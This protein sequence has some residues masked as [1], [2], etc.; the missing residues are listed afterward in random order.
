[1]DKKEI[2]EKIIQKKEFFEL[3]KKEIEK[4]FSKFEKRQTSE[5]EKIR[6]TRDLLRKIYFSFGSRKLLNPRIL[7]KKS[8]EQVLNKHFSTRERLP[9]YEEVYGKIFKT[10][11]T[12][13][14]GRIVFD[15]GAGINGLSYKYFKDK[16]KYFGIEAVGQLVKLMNFYFKKEKLNAK[17]LHLSLFELEK[18]KN[19]LKKEG[20]KGKKVVFLFKTIDS[21]E[22]IERDF[23]KK[24]LREISPLV[25]EIVVSFATRS[26]I[27]R[28]RFKAKRSWLINFLREN[29]KVLDDFEVPGERY[30]IFR[31]E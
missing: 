4:A 28:I 11:K 6:L 12:E 3:P 9:Y 24:F 16:P 31:K 29:F 1:M 26:L 18:I 15:F 22:V 30:I 20:G 5:E 21:L 13:E 25:D 10:E 27:K 8:V 23:S 14:E 7:E 17:A 2:L 19:L